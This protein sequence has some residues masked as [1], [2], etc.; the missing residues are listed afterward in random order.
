M[1]SWF[2][3]KFKFNFND[4]PDKRP[5][6]FDAAIKMCELLGNPSPEM[7]AETF[8]CMGAVEGLTSGSTHPEETEQF[9][10]KLKERIGDWQD[11]KEE[12][13]DW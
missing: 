2:K 5:A 4:I 12:R 9:L 3:S 13:W 1:V 10:D 8:Y 11:D 6:S 7:I